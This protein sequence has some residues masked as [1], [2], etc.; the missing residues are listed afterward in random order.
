MS[1]QE[2]LRHEF[3]EFIPDELE[4]GVIYISME[5]ATATHLCA[6]GCSR[7]VITPISP[8]DW[9]LTFNG[10]SVSLHP[11]VGNWSFPC[12]SH[13][14]LRR[15][16][17]HWARPMRPWQIEAGRADSR[18]R[19]ERHAAGLPLAESTPRTEEPAAPEEG[20]GRRLLRKLGLSL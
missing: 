13:Y 9:E 18:R 12:R 8:T 17:I 4:E 16:R 15:G 6:C 1:R 5:Y 10:S 7:E 3:V 19:K 11:S 20:V 14:W 2:R